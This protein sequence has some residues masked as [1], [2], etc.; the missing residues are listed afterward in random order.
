MMAAKIILAITGAS[1]AIYAREFLALVDGRAEVHALISPSGA[2]VMEMELGMRPADLPGVERW[3]AVDDFTAPMASGSARYDAMAVL[4]CTMGS[5]GAIAAGLSRNLIHRAADVMLKE[6]R[7]LVL[8]VR[9]TPFNST[10]LRNMALAADSGAT[11]CPAMPAFY[12]QPRT[13]G[14]LARDFAAR[15]AILMGIDGIPLREWNGETVKGG[16]S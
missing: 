9:E 3:F 12:H 7:P 5:L 6:R 10:H 2:K 13:I 14:D 15:V 16:S 4:P 1:G 11:I 8:A